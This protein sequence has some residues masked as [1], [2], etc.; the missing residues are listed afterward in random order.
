MSSD[1]DKKDKDTWEDHEGV[2]SIILVAIIFMIVGS[3]LSGC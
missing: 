2:D 1:R 3:M